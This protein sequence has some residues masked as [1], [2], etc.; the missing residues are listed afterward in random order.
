MQIGRTHFPAGL[1]VAYVL[2]LVAICAWPLVAFGS[3]FAFDA[4]MTAA[5]TQSTEVTV[6]LVLGYPAIP[7]LGVLGSFLARRAGRIR[8]AWVLAAFALIPAAV[9]VVALGASFAMN[10]L[11]ALGVKF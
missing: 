6:M 4:P 2:A 5:Q 1:V 7:L 3:A 10:I 11:F 9:L 8:L